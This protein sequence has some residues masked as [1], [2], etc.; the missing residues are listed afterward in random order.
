MLFLIFLSFMY[1]MSINGNIG[2][3]LGTFSSQGIFVRGFF[4]FYLLFAI[5]FCLFWLTNGS[6]CE[7]GWQLK[8]NWILC[9]GDECYIV[10]FKSCTF[11]PLRL[12][13]IDKNDAAALVT[14]RVI[15]RLWIMKMEDYRSWWI[16][17]F[18][19]WDEMIYVYDCW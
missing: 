1:R 5:P 8:S 14:I 2:G 10:N 4:L 19:N 12:I 11:K 6:L 13:Y 18:E 15:L 16:E 7:I 3:W 9:L 17:I